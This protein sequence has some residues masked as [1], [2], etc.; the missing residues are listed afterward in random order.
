MLH[1]EDIISEIVE[2][3]RIADERELEIALEF[4]RSLIHK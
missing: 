1:S 4:I 3:L 2:L